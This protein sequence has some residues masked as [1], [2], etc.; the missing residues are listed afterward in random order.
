M[1]LP[2]CDVCLKSGMLCQGCENKL[3]S[4]EISQMDLD[5]AKILYRV[6]DGKIGFKKTIEI[7]DM[8][9]IVTEKDQ[10]GKLI[11]KSGKIV[12]E[13]SKTI[14]KKVRVVGENSDLRSVAR[15]ILAPARI[16]GI[17]IV[18]GK[19]GQEKYKIRIMRED[20]RRI[21]GKLDVL[22]DII[23]ELTSEK[24]VVVVDRR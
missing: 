15:D 19:D 10:V 17:N 18:Y 13:I 8:V 4:G 11:G 6:G 20:A 1:V 7:G 2:I 16:S 21:P 3:K 23:Q 24:T 5:I 12:R 9:I 14:G 22:N